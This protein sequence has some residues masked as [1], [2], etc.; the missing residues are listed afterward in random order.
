MQSEHEQTGVG[1]EEMAPKQL[2]DIQ[3]VRAY[4]KQ[5]VQQGRAEQALE[6]LLEL[7]GAPQR[8]TLRY[9]GQVAR[10]SEKAVRPQDRAVESEP[11][12]AFRFR[13]AQG[14]RKR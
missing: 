5:L 11:V 12:G 6:M 14:T 3:A 7:F 9:N 10:R 1:P 13:A 2:E 8:C 4:L